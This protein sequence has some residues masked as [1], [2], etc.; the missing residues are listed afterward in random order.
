MTSTKKRHLPNSAAFLPFFLALSFILFLFTRALSIEKAAKNAKPLSAVEKAEFE[1][2]L[3]SLY[4]ER[5]AVLKKLP[6][7]I[8]KIDL[9]LNATSSIL[10]D[11]DSGYILYER[12]ADKII[13]PA[14]MTKLFLIDCVLEK[15]REG[16]AKLSD[17]I[18][19]DQRAWACNAPPRSS[20]MFLG[21][22]HIVSL[23]ELLTGLSVASGNDAAAA[24]AYALFGSME[25]FIEE[26]NALAK[27]LGL[28]KTVIVEASGYS[29]NNLTSPREM[30]KFCRIYIE[31]FPEA[32]EKFHSIKNF[33][34]PKESN[35]PPEQRGRPAQ[36][37]SKGIPEEIWTPFEFENTNKLIGVF[38]GCDG[39]KTGY[40]DESGYNLAMTT[41]TEDE[42]FISVTMNGSGITSAEGDENR[43]KD[44]AKLHD[45]ARK[46]FVLFKESAF[47]KTEFILPLYGSEKTFARLLPK[48]EGS[49]PVPRKSKII[50][51]AKTPKY[52][53]GQIEFGRAYGS[54][55]IMDGEKVLKEI[56]LVA[57]EESKAANQ[58]IQ[59]SDEIILRLKGK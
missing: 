8:G 14:S 51:Q 45:W 57:Q 37:F 59:R 22:G 38:P 28:E 41:K 35:L 21:K 50:V 34:Y 24:I 17:I 58:F 42:R 15:T 55:T 2:K 7:D 19:L 26:A 36:D 47:G 30:A 12:N 25:N 11:S 39:I 54:L 43:F 29:E 40:I 32:L 10:L 52:L 56:P 49:L 48:E 13:P 18:E 6:Y 27:S 33:T 23:E 9:A 4:P 44:G 5:K 16:K 31:R 46:N 3:D 1:K 53:F 20:L